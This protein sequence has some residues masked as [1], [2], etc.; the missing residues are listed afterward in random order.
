MSTLNLFGFKDGTANVTKDFDQVIWT[1]DS[2][3]W[4]KGGTY[5]AIRRIQ[6]FLETGIGQTYRNGKTHLVAIR[7]KWCP[8]W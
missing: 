4:M 7:R 8:L 5:M 1:D 6:M 3:D 2:D